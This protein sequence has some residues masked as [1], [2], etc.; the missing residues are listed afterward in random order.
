MAYSKTLIKQ[1][2]TGIG[3]H[4]YE[5]V[6]V[7]QLGELLMEQ[8]CLPVLD[9]ILEAKTY[10]GIVVLSIEANAKEITDFVEKGLT[11]IPI[12]ERAVQAAAEQISAEY[13]RLYQADIKELTKEIRSIHTDPWQ[14]QQSLL[15]TEPI[16]DEARGFDSREAGYSRRS[17]RSFYAIDFVYTIKNCPYELKP[18]AVYVI[19]ILALVFINQLY[20]KLENCYDA[21]DEW[22]EYYTELVG[23]S[24]CLR[25][26]KKL[27]IGAKELRQLF[28]E[29]KQQII[30]NDFAA[31]LV[32]FIKKQ[33]NRSETYFS[34]SHLYAYSYMLIGSQGWYKIA[35]EKNVAY[36]LER[37]NFEIEITS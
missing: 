31:R 24:H 16:T 28:D 29:T 34:T 35:T 12:S 19:Q 33:A 30:N 26:P 11:T 37:L 14:D 25:C 21:G 13:E 4:I 6:V 22:A 15:F 32:R 36:I 7:N 2:T 3:G 18:L 8:N 17:P 5:H 23:Y 10:D 27:Q 9:Y 1:S 20:Q